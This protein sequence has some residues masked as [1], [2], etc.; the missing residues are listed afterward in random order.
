MTTYNEIDP[1]AAAWLRNLIAAGKI[2]PGDVNEAD[3]RQLPPSSIARRAHFF[4]G[5]GGWPLALD[6]AGFP[7][8]AEVWTGS[9]PCQPFSAAGRKKGFDD[10]R[11]LWPAWFKL[12][13][14][15][16]PP[17]V[18]GEQVASPDGLRWFDAVCSDLEGAGYAVGAADL[19]AAGAGAP[20]IRQRL[21][22]VAVADGERLA[23]LRLQLRERS[24]R[25]AVPEAGRGGEAR[26]LADGTRR[27]RD[28]GRGSFGSA[29][30]AGDGPADDRLVGD[31][32]RA[33]L[34][35][36]PGLA[37]D[38][39]DDAEWIA[40]RDGKLRPV[41]PGTFPLASGVSNRV[42]KLRGYGNALCVEVA[43][44]FVQAVMET[45]ST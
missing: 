45:L 36:R 8:E 4:A 7:R 31:A 30:R 38:V 42:V 5:I 26:G 34:A 32:G 10:D 25:S 28:E 9:C 11:H 16:R 27:G 14:E 33:R 1:K 22:F 12:I 6:M 2:E 19:C 24:A 44:R 40:C 29:E 39:W 13:A 3:V 23:R 20:H 17:I 18:F 21:Y 37:G 35:G 43:V 15:R 41:E